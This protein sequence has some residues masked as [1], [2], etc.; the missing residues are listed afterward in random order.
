MLYI[1]FLLLL[2][3]SPL[4]YAFTSVMLHYSSE[5]ACF[6][7]ICELLKKKEVNYFLAPTELSLI[8][9]CFVLR[10]L[11][12]RYAVSTSVNWNA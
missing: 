8:A 11:A 1:I 2:Q 4:L 9:A 7:C 10:D 3:F 6:R 12:Y 5:Q